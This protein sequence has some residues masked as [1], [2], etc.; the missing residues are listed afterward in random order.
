MTFRKKFGTIKL[1]K[2]YKFLELEDNKFK[3]L[4]KEELLSIQKSNPE[5]I[6][7]I[8]YVEEKIRIRLDNID[9]LILN[10]SEFKILNNYI[11]YLINSK[12]PIQELYLLKKISI[13]F[14]KYDY[15]P[16]REL[17]TKLL[18]NNRQLKNQVIR[19]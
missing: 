1:R 6:L 17:L 3:E 9:K 10:T 18:Q 15:I 12:E 19:Y 4:I 7:N 13:F 14:D 2:E 8:S 16:S 5:Q 11:N